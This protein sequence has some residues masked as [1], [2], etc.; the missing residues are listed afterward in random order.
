MV[1]FM[2]FPLNPPT[3]LAVFRSFLVILPKDSPAPPQGFAQGAVSELIKDLHVDVGRQHQ[4]RCTLA[5]GTIPL[6]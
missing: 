6:K 5:T 1:Y 2:M 4:T 3:C